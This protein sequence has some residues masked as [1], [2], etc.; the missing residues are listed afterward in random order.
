MKYVR[1]KICLKSKIMG[2]G[3]KNNSQVYEHTS[4]RPTV[5]YITK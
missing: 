1:N 5:T 3:K 4:P 2:I